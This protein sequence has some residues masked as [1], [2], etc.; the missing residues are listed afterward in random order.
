MFN[1]TESNSEFVEIV[2]TSETDAI[3]ISNYTILYHTSSSGD[4]LVSINSNYILEPK[5][6]AII[7][8][9]DYDFENGIYKGIIS[10][11]ALVF[12]LD[13][14]S[15][16]SRGMA[17]SS[18][19]SV[20]LIS[21]NNDTVDVYTYS[22]NN[23]KGIS[24]ERGT[25]AA[26]IWLNSKNANGTPGFRNSISPR[27]N[28]LELLSLSVTKTNVTI[29]NNF[30]LTIKIKNAGILL[31]T[32]PILN[33]YKD[34]N[35]DG[36]Q[37]PEEL[38][39]AEIITEI[40]S[41]DSVEIVKEFENNS[42]GKNNFIAEVEFDLDEYLDNNSKMVSV[43]GTEIIGTKDDLIINEIM[44][45]PKSPEPEWIELFNR[46]EKQI[47]INNY[48]IADSKDTSNII[49]QTTMIEPSGYLIITDDSSV[50][51]IY[52]ELEKFIILSLPTFNNS[53]DKII[54]LDSFGRTIDS[55]YYT[56]DWGGNNGKSLERIDAHNSSI[57]SSNWKE[58]LTLATPGKINSVTQKEFDVKIV[59]AFTS[60]KAPIINNPIKLNVKVKNSGKKS[61][62]FKIDLFTD[63]NIDSVK[64]N[65]I[66]TSNS[67][68][69]SAGDSL[70]YQFN[71]VDTVKFR[72]GYI[73]EISTIDDDVSNN[74]FY[75][76]SIPGYP[77]KSILVNEIKYSPKNDEPEWVELYNN[78]DYN[79]DLKDWTIS[80]VLTTPIS[81]KIFEEEFIFPSKTFFVISKG[82]VIYN[83][84][85]NILS[86]VLE[87]KFANLNNDKD[88]IV[89]KDN[90]SAT[91]D[92]VLYTNKIGGKNGESIERVSLEFSSTNS[93]NWKSSIDIENGTPG[94]INSVT[95]KDYDLVISSIST[96]PKFPIKNDKIKISV[97][98]INRGN[99]NVDNFSAI[100]SFGKNS[101]IQELEQINNLSLS[102]GDSL[103]I[104][105]KLEVTIS[106]TLFISAKIE[107]PND[108]D[109]TNNYLEGIVT[110]GFNKN[111][112]LI[113]EVMF[114]PKVGEPVWIEIINN[115]DSTINI[116]G[117]NIGDLQTKNIIID[118]DIFL[119]PNKLLIISDFFQNSIFD[120]DVNVI[121][122]NLPKFS[123]KKDAVIIYDFRNAVID[124]MN[125]ELPNN[126]VKGISLERISLDNFSNDLS[127]W[128]FSLSESGSSPGN[129]NS[130]INIPS[131]NYGD[132]II[133]EIMYEPDSTNSEFVELYN[134]SSN[135]IELGG[136]SIE[137]KKGI[138]FS[139]FDLSK[140]L[141]PDEYF[142][143]SADSN[144]L[145]NYTFLENNKNLSI[146]NISSLGFTNSSKLI[147]LKN[148]RGNI[149]DSLNYNKN[150]HN[151]NLVETK[152]IS[153]ELINYNTKRNSSTNW[154]SSVD[155]FGATP[156][157][158]NSIY[159]EKLV[160]GS[161]LSISPN[162]FSPDN[163]G[164]D[165]YTFI[166][167]K[168]TQNIAQIRLKIFDS[169]GR[170]VRTLA[171]N[172]PSG[173]EG[174]ITFDG[175]DKN[176]N[177]LKIGIYI[178]LL[179]ALNSANTTLEI[180]KDVIVIARK[181]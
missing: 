33:I 148:F 180:I 10:D 115:S 83:Y 65:V 57:D 131:Y 123:S 85:R 90:R 37:Q 124:S 143:I 54:L 15:F 178:V 167:Y 172:K 168:L 145:G 6:Y 96:V 165:D 64:E 171:N 34:V 153:L 86:P 17:N 29:G 104:T 151:S 78:S 76:T 181:L 99:F 94:R 49:A 114:N 132:I 149:I 4:S 173:S 24:D 8:E 63:S 139:I 51:E 157:R 117:W 109:K 18:D 43:F 169:R 119:E 155:D 127:N 14:N 5:Q 170:L 134:N 7:L 61:L 103:V 50:S 25:T 55:V 32:N 39:S 97:K 146:R 175:L 154:S 12:T 23:S 112:I 160:G 68:S 88:G 84:Y 74:T 2:N 40:T 106:D 11:S 144:I 158:E 125:Y 58:N 179:E 176:K 122:T 147:Y 30:E 66:E 133:N 130:I 93:N 59:D 174:T 137:D 26:D 177:P 105:S 108:E 9:G 101:P 69:L 31:A 79:I 67:L 80:D 72:R 53:E 1:P 164:F 150:W 162:P 20:Y 27:E 161:K 77:S 95:S 21:D 159:V 71:F 28:D 156:G 92:S 45:A 42:I 3:D 36:I 87:L 121:Q 120:E 73:F 60:P 91:I 135:P 82:N 16:G 38:L 13:D 48:Q 62:E 142:V 102:K 140:K 89:L 113:N 46:S 116:N 110:S 75:Y 35:F 70:L 56:S 107:L 118:D 100:L 126:I 163:D 136:L 47:T 111:S 44:Y 141:Q 52:P 152:N 129:E 98:I 19:R 41:N 138:S 166:S 22:A 128:I 81:K